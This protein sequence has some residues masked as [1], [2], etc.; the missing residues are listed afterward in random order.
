MGTP[1]TG[2][3]LVSAPQDSGE[4][5]SEPAAKAIEGRS[6]G[7]IAW[8]RLK[9]DKV[10][11]GGGIVAFG[12]FTIAVF[13]RP[14]TKLYGHDYATGNQNLTDPSTTMPRGNYGG[15]RLGSAFVTAAS[16]G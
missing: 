13:A 8:R 6:L 3:D 7:A 4:L 1:L 15:A 16:N 14:L 12:I 9:Q 2:V 11:M 5:S 10:A